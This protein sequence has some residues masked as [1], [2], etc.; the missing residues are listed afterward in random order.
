MAF[1]FHTE[2][3]HDM[4]M[5][6]YLKSVRTTTQEQVDSRAQQHDYADVPAGEAFEAHQHHA[7]YAP[8]SH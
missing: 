1:L 2:G 8:A 4:T 7:E 3:L 6:E 5:A